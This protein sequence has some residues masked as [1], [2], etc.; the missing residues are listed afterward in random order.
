MTR[1]FTVVRRPIW[2]HVLRT[3]LAWVLYPLI[4]ARRWLRG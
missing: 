3:L 4:M 2:V 1:D